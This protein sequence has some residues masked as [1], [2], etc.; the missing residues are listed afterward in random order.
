MN[1]L[2]EADIRTKFILPALEKAG[3]DRMTKIR[4]VAYFTDGRIM[5]PGKMVSRNK[6]K[7]YFG[8]IDADY[9]LA[10]GDFIIPMTEQAAGLLVSPVS[11]PDNELTYLH[12]QRLGKLTISEAVSTSF[13]FHFFNSRF[14]S[15]EL[16]RTSTGAKA[17]HNS[18]DRVLRIPTPLSPLA[19]QFRIVAKVDDLMVLCDDLDVS[20]T[21]TQTESRRLLEAVLFELQSQPE[22]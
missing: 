8:P 17:K 21:R 9:L 15:N 1:D 19:E 22:T 14:F 20:L 18:P 4:E 5:V 7:Y 12:N 2:S 16:W 10:P 11:I 3:W 13:I 6:G